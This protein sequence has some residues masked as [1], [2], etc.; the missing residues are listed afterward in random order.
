VSTGPK[1]QPEVRPY[2]IRSWKATMSVAIAPDHMN[3]GTIEP[4]CCF[5]FTA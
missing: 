5:E 3:E 1:S 4:Y 2:F